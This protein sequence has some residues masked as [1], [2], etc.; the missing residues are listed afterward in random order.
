MVDLH[1]SQPEFYYHDH[2]DFYLPEGHRFPLQKYRL[3]REALQ[4][5]GLAH[6][7]QVIP[8]SAATT[9][10][11]ALAH[12]R[13]YIDKVDYGGLS[14]KEVRRMGFPWSPELAER[15]RHSVGSTIAAC[16]TALVAGMGVNLGGGTHHACADHGQGYCV[17]NDVAVAARVMQQEKRVDNVLVV[18]CDVH[19]GNGTAS[20]L[21]GDDSIFT[22][23]IHG[24][25]N[26]PFRKEAS[27]LDIGLPDNTGDDEYLETLDGALMHI[28]SRF[29]P[30]LVIYLA[31]ADPYQ[32]D[33]LG[34]LALSKAGLLA[35]DRLVFEK[36]LEQGI[37][38]AVV[39]SG[40]YAK[41]V[42]DIVEIH[43]ATLKAG[44]EIF[45]KITT[46]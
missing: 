21:Q 16:R 8:G 44:L 6:P 30:D 26:F 40:G 38:L 43:L 2:F 29:T 45:Q 33:S 1:P 3:L 36:Y 10:Q 22:F 27:D 13:E 18:D 41:N 23:S 9:E 19:Q 46:G 17:Y 11:L 20:I 24:Q 4:A 25:K 28:E 35:R 37:P 15:S 32:G 14:E 34:R 12:T 5:S 39:S 31:G 7:D 42:G